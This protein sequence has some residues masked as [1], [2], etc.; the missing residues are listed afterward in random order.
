MAKNGHH[1]IHSRVVVLPDSDTN[2]QEWLQ[3][4]GV[5]IAKVMFN[6]LPEDDANQPFTLGE[7]PDGMLLYRR[8]KTH[9]DRAGHRRSDVY[10]RT[11]CA[12]FRSPAEFA[13]HAMWLMDAHKHQ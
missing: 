8:D 1:T 4:I 11:S 13:R 6:K 10:L 3:K 5:H 9:S 7:F 2:H 12:T